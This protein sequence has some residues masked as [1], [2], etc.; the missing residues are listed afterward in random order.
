MEY[1]KFVCLN[2]RERRLSL[3]MTTFQQFINHEDRLFEAK[4]LE[5]TERR[6]THRNTPLCADEQPETK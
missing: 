5:D 6:Q 2:T 1:T 4:A 3:M